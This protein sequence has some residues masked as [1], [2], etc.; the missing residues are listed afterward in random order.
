MGNDQAI[1]LDNRIVDDLRNCLIFQKSD[2]VKD[3]GISLEDKLVANLG[4]F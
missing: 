1:D 2:D 3:L 4:K